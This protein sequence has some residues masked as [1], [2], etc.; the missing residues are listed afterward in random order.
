MN[1]QTCDIDLLLPGHEREWL[2]NIVSAMS[3]GAASTTLTNPLWVIKTRLMVCVPK[4]PGRIRR[5]SY[6][7]SLQ[8][9]NERTA[10]RYRNTLD[11]FITIGRH[12]GIRGY[13]KGLG[14]SL[15]GVSHVAVQ[16]PLYEKLKR[17]LRKSLDCDLQPPMRVSTKPWCC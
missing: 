16:F 5:Y 8:T 6:S 1:Q 3:A 7:C 10:Y 17:W 4:N 9:Q 11:A 12:E 2:V 13:Y 14:S 15:L